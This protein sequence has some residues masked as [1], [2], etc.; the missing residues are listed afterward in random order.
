MHQIKQWKPT[1]NRKNITL[2][3]MT[4]M[5]NLFIRSS[6]FLFLS[7]SL[8]LFS[9]SLLVLM[10]LTVSVPKN[11]LPDKTAISSDSV[12]SIFHIQL[13]EHETDV[14]IFHS[15]DSL[16]LQ[17]GV[18]EARGSIVV[19]GTGQAGEK[20]EGGS[21]LWKAGCN[22]LALAQETVRRVHLAVDW[23][24]LGERSKKYGVE[25][26]EQHNIQQL[27]KHVQWEEKRTECKQLLLWSGLTLPI[28]R[29]NI[30]CL[31]TI[32]A[33]LTTNN[34]KTNCFSLR[35]WTFGHV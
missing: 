23:V 14:K 11:P 25:K 17:P 22:N 27:I 16:T 31:L 34:T 10:C 20:G 21:Y 18:C 3:L 15:R 19:M 4:E 5:E 12:V 26:G 32:W 6:Q 24:E 30:C 35:S 7:R 9:L 28:C 8:H 33:L 13:T 29:Y 1:C 2:L